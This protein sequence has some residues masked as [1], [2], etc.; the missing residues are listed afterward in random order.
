MLQ[1]LDVKIADENRLNSFACGALL[2]AS[3]VASSDIAM[4]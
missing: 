3:G 2:Y 4:I 1:L